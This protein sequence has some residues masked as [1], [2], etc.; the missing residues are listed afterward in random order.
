M[1]ITRENYIIVTYSSSFVIGFNY[2]HQ[3]L[4]TGKD[5]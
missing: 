5:K 2:L 4:S 1:Y 3:Q